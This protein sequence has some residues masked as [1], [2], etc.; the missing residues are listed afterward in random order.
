[1]KSEQLEVVL[2]V[3]S[4]EILAPVEQGNNADHEQIEITGEGQEPMEVDPELGGAPQDAD[5]AGERTTNV[6]GGLFTLTV[7]TVE[8]TRNLSCRGDR[9]RRSPCGLRLLAKKSW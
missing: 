5:D 1:M 9:V 8:M 4:E 3:D 2:R 7:W 6:V